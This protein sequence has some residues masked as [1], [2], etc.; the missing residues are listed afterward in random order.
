MIDAQGYRVNV[1]ILLANQDGKV[2]LG[3]RLRQ[4]SWQ[5]PQGGIND[6]EQVEEALYRELW[7]EVGIEKD[8][9]E[10]LGQ[11]KQWL[12]YKIPKKLIRSTSRPICIG[13]K[14]KWFLLKFVGE[15]SDINLN[16]ADKPEF[17]DWQWVKYWYPLSQVIHFK[18]EVYRRALRELAPLLLPVANRKGPLHML[19]N[20]V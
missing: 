8:K 17:D 7:E 1:G 15:D 20:L 3:K 16:A 4:K 10:I 19:D 2:F 14:Q 11:T 5:F 6:Q 13:Q 18:R 9:V 12:K